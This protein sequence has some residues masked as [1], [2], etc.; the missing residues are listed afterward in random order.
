[1]LLRA[2]GRGRPSA[3]V[4]ARREAPVHVDDMARE[5]RA[6]LAPV[7]RVERP[8]RAVARFARR[9]RAFDLARHVAPGRA[10]VGFPARRALR[11]RGAAA[12]GCQPASE[13]VPGRRARLARMAARERL[14]PVSL[15]AVSY[16]LSNRGLRWLLLA[17]A[18]LSA[19]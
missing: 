1:A 5:L 13:A 3:L 17:A 2:R 12:S 8:H 7:P 19:I 11:R 18:C 6:A 4:L 15:H 16:L 14:V 9:G 10:R